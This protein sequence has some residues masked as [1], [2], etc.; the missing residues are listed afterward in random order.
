MWDQKR[1]TNTGAE[2]FALPT[3]LI[4]SVV[5]ILVLASTLVSVSAA[6]IVSMETRHYTTYAKNASQSG[7]VMAYNCLKQNSYTVTWTNANPLRPNTNC[8]GTIQGGVSQYLHSE[9]DNRSTFTVPLPTTVTSGVYRI[10]VTG[11][12]DRLNSSATVWRTYQDTAYATI[13]ST[14]ILYG[15]TQPVPVTLLGSVGAMQ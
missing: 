13:T 7:I 1:W 9:T 4:A 8:S 12:S 11:R 6:T 5:M 14:S 3:I 2:G 15:A 10:S